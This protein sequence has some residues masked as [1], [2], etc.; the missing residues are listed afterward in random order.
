MVEGKLAGIVSIGDVVRKII[1]E[2]QAALVDLENFITGA[3]YGG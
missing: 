1:A 3:G 2:Q